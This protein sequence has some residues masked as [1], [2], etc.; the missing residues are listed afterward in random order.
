MVPENF[1]DMYENFTVLSRNSTKCHLIF[2]HVT[3]KPPRIVPKQ[4]L[5]N[6][7]FISGTNKK[8]IGSVIIQN[9]DRIETLYRTLPIYFRYSSSI[10]QEYST[11]SNGIIQN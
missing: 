10:I 4:I 2:L 11:N 3:E 7:D 5:L 8:S 9:V 6:A 1:P